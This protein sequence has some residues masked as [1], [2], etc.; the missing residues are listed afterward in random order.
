MLTEF[1]SINKSYQIKLFQMLIN[2]GRV[3]QNIP[4]NENTFFR[5]S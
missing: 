1:K 2:N 4:R 5:V 3:L